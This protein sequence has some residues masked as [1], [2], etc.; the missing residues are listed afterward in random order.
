LKENCGVWNRIKIKRLDTL[1]N[2]FNFIKKPNSQEFGYLQSTF[3]HCIASKTMLYCQ[4]KETIVYR[5]K[6]INKSFGNNLKQHKS[7]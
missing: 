2:V 4:K 1:N 5:L 7:N 3:I 6:I